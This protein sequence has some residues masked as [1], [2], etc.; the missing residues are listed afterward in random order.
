MIKNLKIIKGYFIDPNRTVQYYVKYL[1]NKHQEKSVE[2]K[3][4]LSEQ[5]IQG[6]ICEEFIKYWLRQKHILA[7]INISD[8]YSYEPGETANKGY[9][10][11]DAVIDYNDDLYK[12]DFKGSTWSITPLEK[13]YERMHDAFY[14]IH[15]NLKDYTIRIYDKDGNFYYEDNSISFEQFKDEI[16]KNKI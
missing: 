14:L 11:C 6:F 10:N 9:R 13:D 16:L 3:L 8:G 1:N 2:E 5:F 4:R 12:V 7:F 15:Y